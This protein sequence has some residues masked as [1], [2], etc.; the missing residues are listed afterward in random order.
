MM[1]G[2]VWTIYGVGVVDVCMCMSYMDEWMGM[3]MEI[4]RAHHSYM[5]NVWGIG[6]REWSARVH[7]IR[8]VWRVYV[9]ARCIVNVWMYGG[10]GVW[11]HF[12]FLRVEIVN[13]QKRHFFCFLKCPADED[14]GGDNKVTHKYII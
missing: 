10:C 9:D 3:C 7:C 14:K 13:H 8:A 5:S 4:W 1:D 11:R 12:H 2:I 6:H